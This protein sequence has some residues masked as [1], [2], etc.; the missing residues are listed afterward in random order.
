[1]VADHLYTEELLRSC[2]AA[3]TIL[4]DSQYAE[5]IATMIAPL[6]LAS[7]KW[8]S[9]AG[10]GRMAF[11]SKK[12]C[13]AVAAAVLTQP[14]HEGAVYEIT[15]PELLSFRDAAALT[16]EIG[17]RPVEYLVVSHDEKQASFDA[18]GIPRRYVEG[19]V[20]EQSGPWASEEMMS[21]ERA[22][23]EGYFA[24]CSHH[25]E[26]ITGR[27][28]LSLRDVFIANRDALVAK[29]PRSAS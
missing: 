28:A 3:Y 10:E 27:P 21:Y 5:V 22:L 6:A 14:G 23:G 19:V 16:A 13:V 9:S 15:G 12:D 2:G 26:L 24:L 25:V 17:G 1:V 18:A 11:V 20:H 8:V 29:A 4:R 7:G